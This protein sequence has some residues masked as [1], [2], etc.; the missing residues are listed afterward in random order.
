MACS[1][2]KIEVRR[3]QPNWFLTARYSLSR[4]R[5]RG[6]S[7]EP[8]SRK[9]P[10]G[11]LV[12]L[13]SLMLQPFQEAVLWLSLLADFVRPFGDLFCQL[14]EVG[15]IG[16]VAPRYAGTCKN[17][18]STVANCR[19]QRLRE[20][21]TADPHLCILLREFKGHHT[22]LYLVSRLS[23]SSWENPSF[24]FGSFDPSTDL[25]QHV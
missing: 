17:Y 23:A 5:W 14:S 15:E 1:N 24:A 22:H 10:C 16:R 11:Y 2:K 7:T 4:S 3:D 12:N 21:Y 20:F 25:P 18:K 9:Q 8:L 19:Q 13:D 6:V